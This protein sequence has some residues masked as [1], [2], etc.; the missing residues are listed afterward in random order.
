MGTSSNRVSSK[1]KGGMVFK[2]SPAM[3]ISALYNAYQGSGNPDLNNTVAGYYYSNNNRGRAI[4]VLDYN[5]DSV[6]KTVI[7][8]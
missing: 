4:S 2:D 1:Q 3:N 5:K 6:N 7:K 8:H